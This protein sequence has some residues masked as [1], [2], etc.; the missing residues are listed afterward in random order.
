MHPMKLHGFILRT[1]ISQ[2]IGESTA[3]QILFI[4]RLMSDFEKVDASCF[5]LGGL[6]MFEKRFSKDLMMRF[7]AM[8]NHDFFGP[9]MVPVVHL[10]W[11]INSKLSI[12]G[13]LPVC[14]KA[15]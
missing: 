13:M 11:D 12:V 5:Q 14:T 15:V 9:Y 3:L 10:D 4:P 2:K 1:G 6:A 7:G 8:Y